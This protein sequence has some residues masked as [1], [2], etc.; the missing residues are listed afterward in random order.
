[1]CYQLGTG[2][3]VRV[4]IIPVQRIALPISILPLPVFIHLVRG[5]I[6]HRT[7]RG[8]KPHTF[9]QVHR[10]HN[11]GFIGI[12]R[13]LIG[14]PHNGL[15][16]QMNHQLRLYPVKHLPQMF[17]IPDI[18]DHRIN[19]ILQSGYPKKCRFGRRLQ[20]ISCYLCPSQ[21]QNPAQ[22]APLKPCMPCHQYPLPLIKLP[23]CFQIIHICTPYLSLRPHPGAWR[24]IVFLF[25][26]SLT[27]STPSTA[28]SLTATFFPTAA[29]PS[30]YPYT[31][32]IRHG[33]RT[34]AGPLTPAAP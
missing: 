34:S 7:Y 15:C 9:Q 31:A 6:E 33:K 26:Y 12:H 27:L 30:G 14:I 21:S 25:L 11:I 2:L 19:P 3:A 4:G 32:R 29:F 28:L 5:H 17:Q 18:T 13:I 22:P 10:T 1:M 20:R 16:C 8:G 23:A 24:F